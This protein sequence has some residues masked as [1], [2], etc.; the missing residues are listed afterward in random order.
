MIF[1][2][3]AETAKYDAHAAAHGEHSDSGMTQKIRAKRSKKRVWWGKDVNHII[4]VNR[5]SLCQIS[6]WN[7]IGAANQLKG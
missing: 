6:L 3:P 7:L 2:F 4:Q 5:Q 1:H